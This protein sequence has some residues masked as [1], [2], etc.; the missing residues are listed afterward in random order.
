MERNVQAVRMVVA[1]LPEAPDSTIF[2]EAPVAGVCGA[3]TAASPGEAT[4]VGAPHIATSPGEAAC[5]CGP[6]AATSH[7]EA[8]HARG[9]S[10][11][12]S[13]CEAA[14]ASCAGDAASLGEAA[15][16]RSASAA[17]SPDVADTFRGT[18]AEPSFGEATTFRG[19]K[20]V[21]S[22]GE[23]ATFRGAKA[24]PS[25]GEL[26]IFRGAKTEPSLGEA[27]TFRGA[28]AA[29]SLGEASTFRGAKTEP[30]LGEAATFRGTKTEPCLGK[31]GTLRATKAAASIG[32]VTDI[33]GASA[34]ASS[35]GEV[36]IICDASAPSSANQGSQDGE[37]ELLLPG[38]WHKYNHNKYS[39]SVDLFIYC[40][41]LSSFWR[42]IWEGKP[43][44]LHDLE[45]VLVAE[46]LG[47]S[48]GIK[49]MDV[50]E[51]ITNVLDNHPG[52]VEYFRV[53]S[54]LWKANDQL[55][56]W[57]RVLASKGCHCLRTLR[58]GFLKIPA[59]DMLAFEYSSL[60]NIRICSESLVRIDIW[61]S[62]ASWF[63]IE[64][65]PNLEVV[66]TGIQPR[67][68]N[69]HVSISIDG[70]PKLKSIHYI[71][72]PHHEIRIRNTF[73]AKDHISFDCLEELRIG[74]NMASHSQRRAV[75]NM[76]DCLP[77]LS[78]LVLL[79]LDEVPFDELSDIAVDGSFV[80]LKDASCVRMHL[81][82][83][84]IED[85]RGGAAE[86]SLL[87][88]I[89]FFVPHLAQVVLEC[90]KECSKEAVIDALNEIGTMTRAS[91]LAL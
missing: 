61:K 14:H 52:P 36:A 66:T 55:T 35:T 42:P 76:M 87:R 12:A 13:R 7:G 54:S 28:K 40:R 37:D 72:L 49:L 79:R 77:R 86:V 53:D 38:G 67:K 20:A 82:R 62:T 91:K 24:A 59:L 48:H 25:L 6:S 63:T 11:A 26:A 60:K 27:A 88:T 65:A 57:V 23:A 3:S 84:T 80:G 45:L 74:V 19:A 29:P 64:S 58:L 90:Y 44:I 33:C 89:L 85:F 46:Y 31:A 41:P 30:S 9:A 69:S 34:T 10:D 32:E 16:I 56:R 2:F 18:K 5:T 68:G 73:I 75:Q 8:T 70:T 21:P 15:I 50:T 83:F 22:L 17:S 39:Q 51:E 4:H 78:S 1:A 43:L 71:Q 47:R 81:R